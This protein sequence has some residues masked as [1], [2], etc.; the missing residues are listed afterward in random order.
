MVSLWPWRAGDDAASFERALSALTAKINRASARN[1]KRRQTSRRVRVMLTLYAGFAYIVVAALLFLVT[2]RQNWGVNEV[3]VL[4]GSPVVI[5]V[6]RYALTGYFDYRIA[7]TDAY[8]A[9]LNKE[10]DATIA[11]LKEATKYNSTQQLL[12][13][14][15]A[16][17]KQ[18]PAPS[19]TPQ[20]PA[21]SPNPQPHSPRT[22]IAPPPTANIQRSPNPQNHPPTPQR[23]SPAPP[24]SPPSPAISAAPTEE[25]AP[26]AFPAAPKPYPPATPSFTTP[27]W[28]DR[29][30]DALL[31]EDETQAKN[32][33]ALICT[34]CRLVNGQA[35]PGA[36]SAADVGRWRCGA[37]RAW[38]GV[39]KRGDEVEELVRSLGVRAERAEEREVRKERKERKEREEPGGV[40]GG[41]E[42][43]EDDEEVVVKQVEK[44]VEEED[45]PSKATRSRTKAKGRK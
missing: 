13:K 14:Y 9:K 4:A 24:H 23:L 33:L 25:F 39:E 40:K 37:C 10:R 45:T 6:V 44:V 17:P 35:P 32:R 2:G 34:Q 42:D 28:Y 18:D 26:N 21:A 16:S 20:K 1:D 12:E 3:S 7:N 15:G 43:G 11:R 19:P 5:Y 31:G 8:V 36:R 41:S 30:L 27:H 38:N 29:I 22:G